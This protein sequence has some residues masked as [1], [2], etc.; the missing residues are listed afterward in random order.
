MMQWCWRTAMQ[1]VGVKM[2]EC[3]SH[4]LAYPWLLWVC[5]HLPLATKYPSILSAYATTPLPLQNGTHHW[6]G[7][8]RN[9]SRSPRETEFQ[10]GV[11]I[12]N[13]CHFRGASSWTTKAVNARLCQHSTTKAVSYTQN[14]TCL[15]FRTSAKILAVLAVLAPVWLSEYQARKI[16]ILVSAADKKNNLVTVSTA[17]TA[18]SAIT[19]TPDTICPKVVMNHRWHPVVSRN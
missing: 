8:K 3:T 17:T 5:H 13:H 7:C 11:G 2:R 16:M 14:R 4:G 12:R 15:F 9:H 1:V 10:M 19:D 6:R 18:T